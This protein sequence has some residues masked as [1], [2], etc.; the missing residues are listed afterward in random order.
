VPVGALSALYKRAAEGGSYKVDVSLV[1]WY[2]CVQGL[3]ELPED[4]QDQLFKDHERQLKA[5][6]I[7]HSSNFDVV[8]K[9]R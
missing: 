2:L 9:L 3:G 5:F 6:K 4:V 1:G 7:N 8:S